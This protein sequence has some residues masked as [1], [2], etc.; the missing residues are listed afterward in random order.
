M[1]LCNNL[2]IFT[3]LLIRPDRPEGPDL[4]N[5]MFGDANI[6]N[7]EGIYFQSFQYSLL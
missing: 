4:Q 1:N 3:T 2:T 7:T 6:E 5:V